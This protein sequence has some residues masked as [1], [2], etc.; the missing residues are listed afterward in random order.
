MHEWI[1]ELDYVLMPSRSPVSGHEGHYREAYRVWSEA[2]GKFRAEIGIS[3]KLASDGFLIP[4]ETGAIFYQGKCVALSAFTHGDLSGGPLPDHSWWNAWSP[5]AYAKLKA[6]SEN[7]IICSQFTVAPEFAGKNQIVRWKD[8]L[9]L[10]SLMR[11][12]NSEADV[13]A[14]HLNLTRGM[15]NA[16]G[17][18]NGAT[19]LDPC[20]PFSFYGKMIDAQLVAYEREKVRSMFRRKELEDLCESLWDR[21]IHLS[22]HPVTEKRRTDHLKIAA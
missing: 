17:E 18:D 4:H 9:S 19:V 12:V 7:V 11:F 8:I 20:R 22:S 1:K 14:G 13:M 6:L 10:L 2:W 5:E 16:C 3:E 15:Q 21:L